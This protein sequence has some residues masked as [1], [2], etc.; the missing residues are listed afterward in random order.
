MYSFK[1]LKKKKKFQGSYSLSVALQKPKPTNQI[2]EQKTLNP[3]NFMKKRHLHRWFVTDI[4]DTLTASSVLL[5]FEVVATNEKSVPKCISYL[6]HCCDESPG[7]S[8]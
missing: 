4:C 7:R 2:N 6:S 8:N 5:S 1:P 3:S